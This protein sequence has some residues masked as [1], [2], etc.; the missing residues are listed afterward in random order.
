MGGATVSYAALCEQPLF[1]ERYATD[2]AGELR[3]KSMLD[4]GGSIIH[5]RTCH[6]LTVSPR[7]HLDVPRNTSPKRYDV[8]RPMLAS[9]ARAVALSLVA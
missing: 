6:Q 4:S 2:A 8:R 7:S 9:I 3:S 5:H 1:G